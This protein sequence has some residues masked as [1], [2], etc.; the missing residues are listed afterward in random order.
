MFSLTEFSSRAYSVPTE[1]DPS[2]SFMFGLVMTMII[3]YGRCILCDFEYPVIQPLYKQLCFLHQYLARPNFCVNIIF[4]LWLDLLQK[5]WRLWQVEI[6]DY[7]TPIREGESWPMLLNGTCWYTNSRITSH[8]WAAQL[9]SLAH[10]GMEQIVIVSN[11]GSHGSPFNS[12]VVISYLQ[13]SQTGDIWLA[14]FIPL[15]A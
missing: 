12:L 4:A 9:Q 11:G 1:K 15:V 5:L 13:T 8:K 10:S 3:V 6:E 2:K 14:S 7:L